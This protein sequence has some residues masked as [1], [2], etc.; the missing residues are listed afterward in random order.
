M[1]AP[2][3]NAISQ[4]WPTWVL[5]MAT[6]AGTLLLGP[7]AAEGTMK[8]RVA[9]LAAFLFIVYA[10][11]TGQVRE[12]LLIGWAGSLTYNRQ[13]F[14]FAPLTGD[15]GTQGPYVIVS[16]IFLAGLLL[17]WVYRVVVRREVLPA[18]GPPFWLWYAPL[19]AISVFS[20]LVADRPDWAAYE[21]LRVLRL[22]LIFAYVRR[23]FGIREWWLALIAGGLA[24]VGQAAIGAKEVIT[25]R[26]GLL[27]ADI[28][29][30]IGQYE[31]AF[32]QESFYGMVRATGTMNHPPNLACYLMSFIPVFAGL[33]FTARNTLLRLGALGIAAAGLGGLVC[34]MSRLPI[35]L[36]SAELTVVLLALVVVRDVPVRQ[37]L[38]ILLVSIALVIAVAIPYRDK[39][40]DRMT[41]DFTASVDQRAEGN[42]IALAMIEERPWLGVGLNNSKVHMLKHAPDLEWAFTNEE[43]LVTVMH[44]RSIA[45]MGNG[46]LFIAVEL[47]VVG[48]IAYAIFLAGSLVIGIR[49]VAK[50]RGAVRGACLGILVGIV[51]VLLEQTID[52]SVWVDPQLYTN[53]LLLGALAI[54][55][56]LSSQ[57]E[58]PAF[59]N[60]Q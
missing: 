53:A 3:S 45:A 31:G 7:W 25:G 55:P 49:A 43:F 44:S 24:M 56:A 60:K 26:S 39:I 34:T 11:V 12:L 32:D 48:M 22:L 20:L 9:L 54:A 51:A 19:A 35:A 50:T 13:Y 59:A 36:A 30:G 1:L 52:F 57:L 28:A 18:K 41:R 46:F 37:A 29:T 23:C 5:L 42:R 27:G 4:R 15:Q 10:A 47:G 6:I 40:I 16:D 33:A 14:L 8:L 17:E 38:G 21:L 58:R 2:V